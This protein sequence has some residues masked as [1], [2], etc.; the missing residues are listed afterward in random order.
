MELS[1]E[2]E[3]ILEYGVYKGH[4]FWV[5]L[6]DDDYCAWI[7]NRTSLPLSARRFQNYLVRKKA[8]IS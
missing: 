2:D 7:Y 8:I 5:V 4:P 3:Q 6:L 1:A